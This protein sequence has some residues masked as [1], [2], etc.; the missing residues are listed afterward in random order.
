MAALFAGPAFAQDSLR[1]TVIV[2]GAEPGTGQ[3]L[4][5]LFDSEASYLKAPAREAAVPIDAAGRATL[6]FA[7][8]KA[9]TYA[10]SVIYDEDGDGALDTGFLGIP[11]ELVAMSNNARG[12]FGPP[13]FEKTRFALYTS[14]TIEIRFGKAR[15]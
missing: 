7:G 2:S 3:A 9:G 5:S 14:T 12:R 10:V 13:G 8:L 1:L 11:T 4:A 6:T 15:E